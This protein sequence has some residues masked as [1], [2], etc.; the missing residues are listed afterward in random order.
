MD[1]SLQGVLVCCAGRAKGRSKSCFL[2]PV[3]RTDFYHA[4]MC[5]VYTG[6]T[7]QAVFHLFP[8]HLFHKLQIH[9][10]GFFFW[11]CVF[12]RAITCDCCDRLQCSGW[13]NS[14]FW[15]LALLGRLQAL[16]CH[17]LI[18]PQPY[19]GHLTLHLYFLVGY[20]SFAVLWTRSDLSVFAD[21]HRC[22]GGME[23]F[24]WTFLSR[25]K[26][27]WFSAANLLFAFFPLLCPIVLCLLWAFT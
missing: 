17:P 2:P 22:S 6:F 5:F 10:V 12:L 19:E 11:S 27:P 24:C 23:Y 20:F 1:I 14:L 21:L 16:V 8:W 25:D 3:K 26:R 7:V 18:F 4:L 13:H 9:V 15:S